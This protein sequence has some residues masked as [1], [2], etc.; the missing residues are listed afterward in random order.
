MERED[1]LSV[2]LVMPDG[3]GQPDLGGRPRCVD[4]TR[5]ALLHATHAS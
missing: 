1:A 3:H 4:A 5:R 2:D